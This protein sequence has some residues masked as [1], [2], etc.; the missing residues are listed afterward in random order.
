MIFE[1]RYLDFEP[2]MKG[3]D[4]PEYSQREDNDGEDDDIEEGVESVE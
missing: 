3:P 4:Y 2:R 1:H